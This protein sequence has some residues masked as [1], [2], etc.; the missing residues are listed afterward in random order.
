MP[1]VLTCHVQG[2]QQI[3]ILF[4]VCFKATRFS[5]ESWEEGVRKMVKMADDVVRQ[6]DMLF[7][8]PVAS[9]KSLL[10]SKL[11]LKGPMYGLV[12]C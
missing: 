8:P 1:C 11:Y 5:S 6:H 10:L 7:A 12:H 9:Q 2:L 4:P 3:Q